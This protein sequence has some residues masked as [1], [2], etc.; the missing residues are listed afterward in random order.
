MRDAPRHSYLFR[1]YPIDSFAFSGESSAR[2]RQ[3]NDSFLAD[4]DY[5]SRRQSFFVTTE[6]TPPQTSVMGAVRYWLL[7][8]NGLIGGTPDTARRDEIIGR[9]SFDIASPSCD[10]GWIESVSPVF[11]TGEDEQENLLLCL[12]APRDN[13][14]AYAELG[15]YQPMR[16][17]EYDAKTGLRSGYFLYPLKNENGRHA[18]QA[19]A[20]TGWRG[21]QCFFKKNKFPSYAIPRD[22]SGQEGD[23]NYHMQERC[24][25]RDAAYGP[26]EGCLLHPAFSV[27]VT[28]KKEIKAAEEAASFLRIGSRGSQFRTVVSPCNISLTGLQPPAGRRSTGDYRLALL[29]PAQ[30]PPDWRGSPLAQQADEKRENA[31]LRQAFLSV[32]P[33]RCARTE[34]DGGR[35]SLML[36]SKRLYFAD[37][38]S[39]L[40][41]DTEEKRDAFKRRLAASPLTICGFNQT[42]AY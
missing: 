16:S 37:T 32:R 39:V 25:L 14:H 13:L 36:N 24:V 26:A 9:N 8:K 7:G 33:I 27:I 4:D 22:A 40:V 35:H 2:S 29:A 11:L 20:A 10:M 28:L 34:W 18:L 12:P 38:G 6:N 1:F 41:F 23:S 19:H 31:G 15:R 42:M 3:K 17:T 5:S 21:E 30:L